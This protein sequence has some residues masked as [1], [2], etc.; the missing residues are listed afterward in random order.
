MAGLTK[1]QLADMVVQVRGELN[2]AEREIGFQMISNRELSKRVRDF[3]VGQ[4]ANSRR[5][6]AIRVEKIRRLLSDPNAP[7]KVIA[8]GKGGVQ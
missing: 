3:N 8:G 7:W 6:T 5:G 4:L 1:N 2:E